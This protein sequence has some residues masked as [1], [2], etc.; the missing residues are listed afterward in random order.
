MSE[1]NVVLVGATHIREEVVVP[2][3]QVHW[4]VIDWDG[5]IPIIYADNM[6]IYIFDS[7][8]RA[9]HCLVGGSYSA[10]SIADIVT[11]GLETT[12]D[13]RLDIQTQIMAGLT[14]QRASIGVRDRLV[15]LTV[16]HPRTQ[17][18]ILLLHPSR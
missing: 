6:S 9:L 15:D 17:Q 16:H 1:Q 11:S 3:Q 13:V 4:V 8:G 2:F 12:F 7:Q 10:A 18:R 5:K 14:N